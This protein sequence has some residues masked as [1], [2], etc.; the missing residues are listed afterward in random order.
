MWCQITA[1]YETVSLEQA[2]GDLQ[3]SFENGD[4]KET[5]ELVD[6]FRTNHPNSKKESSVTFIAAQAALRSRELNR[7]RIEAHKLKLKFPDSG[8]MDDA[9]MI[10][11]ECD[12]MSEHWEDARAHLGWILGFS[13]DEKLVS[14]ARSLIAELDAFFELQ[15]SLSDTSSQ[16]SGIPKIGLILP[17]SAPETTGARAFLDG[18]RIG[19]RQFAQGEFVVF[20]SEGDPIRAVRLAQMLTGEEG[21]WG[22]IGGLDPSEAAGLAA[23]AK[24]EKVPFLTTACGVGELTSIG[25]YIFQGRPD[26]YQIGRAL[27]SYAMQELGLAQFGI[28]APMNQTGR[29]IVFGFKESVEPNGGAILAEE[30]YYPGA[31]DFSMIDERILML[32]KSA[33]QPV[34]PPPGIEMDPGE[35]TT[36][37]VSDR[38]LD[39]LWIADHRR[40]REWMTL[41]KNEIDSLEIPLDVYDGFLLVVEPDAVEIL[42]PQFARFNLNTQLLGDENWADR[43]A[44]FRVSN[45]VEG[46][47]FAEPMNVRG[48]EEYYNFAAGIS[49]V[50]SAG[51]TR[52]HLEGERA[53]RMMAFAAA[54]AEDP[55]SMRIALSQ[56]R[57]LE[58]YSGKVSLLKEERTDRRVTL[59]RF[60]FGEFELVR[61]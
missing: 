58:T 11:A 39:S 6:R 38:L 47:V 5:L 49:G 21:V 59:V 16:P 19:W 50:D 36:W 17:L 42:A 41:T 27:G 40:L 33:L 13:E 14:A 37:T 3:T 52:R 2:Y 4:L 54:R 60:K 31:Q 26:Y 22:F 15:Q 8:Y 7:A 43:E 61:E 57:D 28:L 18:F 10:L 1:G 46:L 35:D 34:L 9:R 24:A 44:L 30:A 29:Q 55:E 48:G 25:R 45:Y 51:V 56:I 53:A 23:M 12:V 20:D 32:D